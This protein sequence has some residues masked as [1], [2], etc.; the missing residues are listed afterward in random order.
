MQRDWKEPV[1]SEEAHAA[2]GQDKR[3]RNQEAAMSPRAILQGE[4]ASF[5][6]CRRGQHVL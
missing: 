2:W 1:V 5:C 4:A 3:G 6:A